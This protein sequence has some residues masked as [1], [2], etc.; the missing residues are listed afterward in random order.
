[1]FVQVGLDVSG[2]T[3]YN[4]FQPLAHG[5]QGIRSFTNINGVPY[6]ARR[7]RHNGETILATTL[8]ACFTGRAA[9]RGASRWLS[10]AL[11]RVLTAAQVRGRGVK[12]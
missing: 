8:R 4:S 6:G 10:G 7:A 2:M 12:A 5:Q 3:G 11:W 9:G 1:M